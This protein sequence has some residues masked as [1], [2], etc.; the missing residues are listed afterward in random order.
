LAGLKAKINKEFDRPGISP[1]RSQK[2]TNDS[3]EG[4]NDVEDTGNPDQLYKKD[5]RTGKMRALTTKEMRDEELDKAIRKEKH[6]CT[7]AV[8]SEWEDR[9]QV[10]IERENGEVLVISK[11]PPASVPSGQRPGSKSSMLLKTEG[12]Q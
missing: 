3:D 4:E 11:K 10:V 6:Y 7:N 9:Q 1:A 2:A 12:F 8:E 5:P